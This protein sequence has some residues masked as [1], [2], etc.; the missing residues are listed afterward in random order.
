MAEHGL[1]G[2]TFPQMAGNG[3]KL[4]E[5]HLNGWK[6]LKIAVNRIKTMI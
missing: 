4:L 6:L 3:L 1:L 2:W 5:M